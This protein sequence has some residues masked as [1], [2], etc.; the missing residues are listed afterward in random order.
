MRQHL[1]LL[2]SE[3]DG[4]ISRQQVLTCGASTAYLR[5]RLRRRDWLRTSAGV[6]ITHTG[7][8]TWRQ[9]AWIAV[10]AADNAALSHQSALDAAGSTAPAR[11]PIH[12]AVGRKRR[13]PKLPGVVVHRCERLSERVLWTTAPPRVRAE[14]AV[15]DVA[16]GAATEVDTIGHL[17]RTVQL[18]LTTSARLQA[19][20]SER[21]RCRRRTLITA[22]LTDIA[23][24]TQSVLE[25][26]YLERVERAH[27]LPRPKRQAP[28]TVGRRGRRDLDYEQWGLIL[29]LD[30][31]MYHDG[32]RQRDLDLE[33]DLDATV[34]ANRRTVRLGWG[35]VFTRPCSTAAK[36]AQI[37][38]RQGWEGELSPCPNCPPQA[39]RRRQ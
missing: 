23:D 7:P 22:V 3:Q 20:L 36:I 31:M 16:E 9:R 35:Q 10:L 21:A 4:V 32:P 39:Q 12:I 33:R 5:T 11:G 25:H 14:H 8:R 34:G 1:T 2:L 37:L 26:G 28:T 15:L 13:A 30:G 27:H 29:E 38:R 18:G 24:G 19:A 17:T 6:Y